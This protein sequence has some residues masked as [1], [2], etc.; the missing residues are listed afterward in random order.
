MYADKLIWLLRGRIAE[1]WKAV[2]GAFLATL[3]AGILCSIASLAR[4]ITYLLE[5]HGVLLW[6]FFF[7]LILVSVYLVGR[8]INRWNAWTLLAAVAGGFFAYVIPLP[9]R[10]L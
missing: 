8:E 10:W 6:S 7:G 5:H 3:L 1:T 2:D 4:L 9:H